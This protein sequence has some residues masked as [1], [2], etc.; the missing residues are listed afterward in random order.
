M[1]PYLHVYRCA[2]AGTVL[3]DRTDQVHEV[4]R[5]T[6]VSGGKTEVDRGYRAK[7]QSANQDHQFAGI[8]PLP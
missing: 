6:F 1:E 5:N 8:D 7:T 2:S 4:G 3:V